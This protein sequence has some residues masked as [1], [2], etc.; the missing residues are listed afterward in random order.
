MPFWDEFDDYLK[1]YGLPTAIGAG[2]G[3]LTGGPI[4]AGVGA[5]GGLGSAI[6]AP[7]AAKA[8]PAGTP[9]W[10]RTATE[11]GVYGLG[12]SFGVGTGLRA[13]AK[14]GA[15][16][17]VARLM[18][19]A[20]FKDLLNPKVATSAIKFGLLSGAGAAAGQEGLGAAGVPKGIGA[21]LGSLAAPI[22]GPTAFGA[23]RGQAYRSSSQT[24][25]NVA[26]LM[27][28]NEA[29]STKLARAASPHK[30]TWTSSENMI[31]TNKK[32]AEH[33]RNLANR[34]NPRISDDEVLVLTGGYPREAIDAWSKGRMT[35]AQRQAMTPEY[36][37]AKR[38][39]DAQAARLDR[40][41]T[42]VADAQATRD[43]IAM[44]TPEGEVVNVPQGGKS[45]GGIYVW[46][47]PDGK[48]IPIP[49]AQAKQWLDGH[50][51]LVEAMAGQ[52]GTET[53]L[54]NTLGLQATAALPATADEMR[55]LLRNTH[56][57]NWD[58]IVPA[59]TA[60]S[61]E[62]ASKLALAVRDA[63]ANQMA[64][65]L[66]HK[67]NLEDSARKHDQL[68]KFL[69]EHP[70]LGVPDINA[71]TRSAVALDNYQKWSAMFEHTP[72]KI[73]RAKELPEVLRN[74]L[75]IRRL[76]SGLGT[77][78]VPQ[79]V[80]QTF[81]EYLR[82][83]DWVSKGS[84]TPSLRDAKVLEMF[85]NPRG[86]V[87]QTFPDGTMQEV[88]PAG[89]NWLDIPTGKAK[90][91]TLFQSADVAD[92]IPLAS[93]NFRFNNEQIAALN[94]ELDTSGKAQALLGRNAKQVL[95]D[96]KRL[97]ELRAA[98]QEVFYRTRGDLERA[99][100][101]ARDAGKLGEGELLPG[102]VIEEQMAQSWKDFQNT[103]V[104]TE[105][106]IES[107][108]FTPEFEAALI[109]GRNV[110]AMQ[111][112]PRGLT[113][114][115]IAYWQEAKNY[116]MKNL[117]DRMSEYF[118]ADDPEI[119]AKLGA[120]WTDE[121]NMPTWLKAATDKAGLRTSDP[122]VNVLLLASRT[123]ADYI[124]MTDPSSVRWFGALGQWTKN[125]LVGQSVTHPGVMAMLSH[126]M[127]D[128][129][130]TA[131]LVGGTYSPI[132]MASERLAYEVLNKPR[133]VLAQAGA[134]LQKSRA[135]GIT[136][137]GQAL[138]AFT[139][140]LHPLSVKGA[141]A[142]YFRQMF[143]ESKLAN[144][145][146]GKILKNSLDRF[147]AAHPEYS[148]Q[149]RNWLLGQWRTYVEY[150]HA[151]PNIDSR[152]AS[153]ARGTQYYDGLVVSEG[154]VF[155]TS[156]QTHARRLS[157]LVNQK[158]RSYPR[159]EVLEAA[160]TTLVDLAN[161]VV[162]AVKG[163][164]L[165]GHPLSE[166]LVHGVEADMAAPMSAY[167][168]LA[169]NALFQKM[170]GLAK[171]GEIVTDKD[172][173]FSR[174]IWQISGK[175]K[176]APDV[177]D[178]LESLN[179]ILGGRHG[180]EGIQKLSQQIAFGNLAADLSI[181]GIQGFKFA[182]HSLLA[183]D[184]LRAA[185]I[186]KD[187][188]THIMSDYGFY[189]WM[190]ANM[191]EIS[192]YSSLG[193]T[194]GTKG[195]IAGPDIQKLPLEAIPM[196][197]KV[198]T[199][200][201]E[202]TDLQFNRMLYYWKVEGIRSQLEFAKTMRAVGRDVA[203]QFIDSSPG[204]KA[205]HDD[206]G[207]L[208]N[209]LLG[210]KEDVLK[211]VIRQVNRSYGGVNLSAEGVGIHRQALEQIMLIVPG[212][213]RAQAGQWAAVVTKPGTLEGQLAI[214]MLAREYLF[215]GSVVT[216]MA[217]M[218]GTEDKINYEDITKPTWLGLP[219]PD[220]LGGGTI[221]IL[222]TMAIPRLAS[223]VLKETVT[224]AAAGDIPN[225]ET[226]LESFG[227]GRLSPL[228]SPLYDMY[229]G[230]DFFGRKYTS[231]ADKYFSVLSQTVLPIIGSTAIEDTK[232][233]FRQGMATGDYNWTD[234]A[235]N[236]GTQ[237]M[238]KGL[239]PQKPDARLNTIANGAYGT[240]WKYLTDSEKVALRAN[241]AVQAAEADYDYQ[242]S[243]R[244]GSEE[245][246]IDL[247]YKEYNKNVQ[248][249]WQQPSMIGGLASTQDEDDVM[250]AQGQM[251]GDD[252]RDRYQTRQQSISQW[253]EA[254]QQ[255]LHAEGYDSEKV[256]QKRM[257]RLASKR[258][259]GDFNWLVQQAQTEYAGV[260]PPLRD[261]EVMTEQGLATFKT[262]DWDQYQSDKLELLAQYPA[263]VANVVANRER[264]DEPEGIA[265]YR[266]ASQEQ[267]AI[268]A[269]PR[270]RGLSVEQGNKID[271]MRSIIQ[272]VG[273]ELRA[274]VPN[275]TNIPAGVIQALA[276]K[277][278]TSSGLL[279]DSTDVTLLSVAI[280]MA[281][282]R[283][284][285][286]QMRNPEQALAVLNSP[287]AVL[288]YPYLRYR[289]PEQL[290]PKLPQQIFQAPVV[291]ASLKA[292]G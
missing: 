253:Y 183:G 198:F 263:E 197:G 35:P 273:D 81:G 153:L 254:L 91:R 188:A 163:N 47:T 220:H 225:Y 33:K 194:G 241:P 157:M 132:D 205:I 166:F 216:G 229:S 12:G 276:I 9:D 5:A 25:R 189:S 117:R 221:S 152:F 139:D 71:N 245:D 238:G 269:I 167:Q 82:Y 207:G 113:Q 212:F 68:V 185:K 13:A 210:E 199:G 64:K 86:S 218:L 180:F 200:I 102:T 211:A 22:A 144:T 242:S 196:L 76:P 281:R 160:N 112:P 267:K 30:I 59:G 262:I 146:S 154:I 284:T 107:K 178:S 168:S 63:D 250:L 172:L 16:T 88:F 3:F 240:D 208:D 159:S 140:Q 227:R 235:L 155:G 150:S 217:K 223:R 17:G 58:A 248:N 114:D 103:L 61:K 100:K 66:T 222:P 130:A 231:N 80:T 282:N 257:E 128:L 118:T 7:K 156:K 108:L 72:G 164:K 251:T 129:E 11:Y 148:E 75:T 165:G 98:D 176:W 127:G 109:K 123:P 15:K 179:D 271:A 283:K 243:R 116:V 247:A 224:S 290:W 258:E 105:T 26:S 19:N 40:R 142:E 264:T 14:V 77:I 292:G 90:V 31:E 101:A 45:K 110:L 246:H 124:G 65:T 24:A 239:I 275:T 8:L 111:K 286:E 89:E 39:L 184:P 215:A 41:M 137:P 57:P 10:L 149:M 289:V 73:I 55:L 84:S 36:A 49:D 151:F 181:L 193:L 38:N 54:R 236:T 46:A 135:V 261:V 288:F 169:T 94:A 279:Q 42:A 192:Y 126:Y 122:L 70:D 266:Q 204:A 278:M 244:A 182:A 20:A 69:Q 190:R 287:M 79:Q 256:R 97:P 195:Y 228:A 162:Q 52:A 249:V 175:N 161:E 78:E 18:V 226:Y 133:G 280:L 85:A 96:R 74:T 119:L 265:V 51:K 92:E 277:Q 202:G 4:G 213:F 104:P 259:P 56:I 2:V 260:H 272:K 50:A 83:A 191:D 232:E 274:K 44:P 143:D 170:K 141:R 125:K 237:L 121:A 214:S 187:S 87:W 43:S 99:S 291:A 115:Q 28:A 173:S 138:A 219:M 234:V 177:Q 134:G 174:G 27:G 233:A 120:V 60:L 147:D 255:R 53:Q 34:L 1:E 29:N 37:K 93:L 201:R 106:T 171:P 131:T 67:A 136:H 285:A 158:Y 145:P 32:I 268:E 186:M 203:A 270:Y 21:F 48:Q 23:L 6:L 230:E 252:W 209:Y 206:M 95:A 62:E